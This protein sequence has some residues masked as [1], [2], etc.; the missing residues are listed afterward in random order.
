MFN[1]I[2]NVKMQYEYFRMVYFKVLNKKK[3]LFQDYF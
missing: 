1:L 3:H 2:L